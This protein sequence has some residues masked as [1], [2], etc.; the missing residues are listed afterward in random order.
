LN[1]RLILRAIA[2]EPTI[3][4]YTMRIRTFVLSGLAVAIIGLSSCQRKSF[5][6]ALAGTFFP[7]RPG[8]TWTYRVVEHEPATTFIL[9]DRVLGASRLHRGADV[10][11]VES[12]YSGRTG[13]LDSSIRYVPEHGY[14]T[15]QLIINKGSWMTSE[16]SFIP[17]R[18]EPDL[19]WSNSLVPFGQQPGTFHIAQTH[20]TFFDARTI[21][22]PAGHF[23]GC[24]RIETT[25]LYQSSFQG[26]PPLQLHYIDW[27]A[28]HVGLVKTLVEHSGLFGSE[29]ARIELLSFGYAA[30]K[31][32]PS[33]PVSASSAGVRRGSN[34]PR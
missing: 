29:A 18:L 32:L 1:R 24:I 9:R 8:F 34:S 26:N 14:L 16:T 27:Y 33:L 10:S 11:Q 7:L 4:G 12:E 22:V 17:Q 21:E 15:R 13:I 25:A 28:P 3:K 2:A 19:T 20:R 5:D 6:P 23:A 31:T 30:P